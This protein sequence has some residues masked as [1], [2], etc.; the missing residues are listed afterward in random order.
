M[1]SR[2]IVYDGREGE[3]EE[4]KDTLSEASWSDVTTKSVKFLHAP[5]VEMLTV[6]RKVFG[7]FTGRANEIG[8]ALH[9]IKRRKLLIHCQ[10][11]KM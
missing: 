11:K 5:K 8:N 3:V 4:A 7:G 2:F 10:K 1:P 9:V 6:D